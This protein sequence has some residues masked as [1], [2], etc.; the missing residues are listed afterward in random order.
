MKMIPDHRQAETVDRHDRRIVNQ[1]GLLLQIHISRLFFQLLFNCCTDSFFH[2][3][4]RCFRISHN[5]E[6]VYIRG[7]IFIC[8][9]GNNPFNK[10]RCL[11]GTCCC[12]YENVA[13]TQVDYF[14][15]FFCPFYAHS[16]AS[17]FSSKIPRRS[18][19]EFSASSKVYFLNLLYSQP[20]IL[21]SNPQIS[22]H[23]Q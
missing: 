13:V 19:I 8:Y 11:S 23:P 22:L 9:P 21:W 1:C 20:S 10:Y 5:Q 2:L 18:F 3:C 12:R 4:R 7:I 16:P 6:T 14:L 15:L 17:P